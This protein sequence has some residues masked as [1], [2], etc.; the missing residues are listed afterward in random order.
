MKF[1]R[2]IFTEGEPE[3]YWTKEYDGPPESSLT[4][5]I[6]RDVMLDLMRNLIDQLSMDKQQF[7]I[8]LNGMMEVQEREV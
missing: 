6:D 5:Y 8:S 2:Y 7:R 1:Y 4:V 3:G